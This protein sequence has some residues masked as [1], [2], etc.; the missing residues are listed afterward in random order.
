MVAYVGA[1]KKKK[2]MITFKERKIEKGKTFQEKVSNNLN[3][4]CFRLLPYFVPLYFKSIVVRARE[5]NEE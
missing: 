5:K 4:A 3:K 2:L 1:K